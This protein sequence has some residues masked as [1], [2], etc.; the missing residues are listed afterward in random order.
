MSKKNNDDGTFPEKWLKKMP[1]G[2]V[3]DAEAM[4]EADL[5]KTIVSCENNMCTIEKEAEA[6]IKLNAAKELVKDLSSAYR[7][8][9]S[10][11]NAKIR[12]CLFLLHGKG[13][14]LDK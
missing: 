12:Y 14:D 3:E 4:S 2:F 1:T 6:D 9:K 13:V 10:C 5:K 11:Q 8:G 7:D